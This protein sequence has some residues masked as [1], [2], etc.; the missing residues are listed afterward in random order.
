MKKEYISLAVKNLRKR[1]LRSW[2][3]MLGIFISIATI[4]VLITLSLGLKD[5]VNEQFRSLGTDKFFITPKGQ[6][7]APGTGGA[8]QLT[9]EDVNVIEKVSGIKSVSY[10]VMGSAKVVFNDQTRY[11]YAIGL[12]LDNTAVF[13]SLFESM[14]LKITQGKIFEQNDKG[15]VMTGSLYAENV[16]SK[17]VKPKDRIIIND[18]EFVVKGILSALGNPSDDK[19]IYMALDDFKELYNSQDR[20]DQ[21]I[22]QIESGENLKEIAAKVEKK[23]NTFRN[24]NT[25]TEDYSILTPEELLKSFDV[26]LNIITAFLLGVSAISLLVG[27][28]G[29]AN[30]MYTSV[31]ERTKEIGVMKSIG[32]KNSDVLWIFLI[33]SGLLGLAGG[34]IGIILGFGISKIIEFIAVNQFNTSLLK[35]SFNLW[36]VLFC[37]SFSFLVGALSGIL[38]AYRASKTNTVDALRYE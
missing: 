12:P 21:I 22:V 32:A 10:M 35:V 2:L 7:G 24:V 20:V 13:E 8:V 28:I 30:T 27:G 4:F 6:L 23:L 19:N 9:I 38:P 18:K 34:V 36:L 17:P 3:T 33:E 1:K 15:V 25:K 37:L 16:F 29:I 26:I 31:L 5:A 11:V 14:D